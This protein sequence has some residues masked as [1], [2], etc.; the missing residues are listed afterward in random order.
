M[1]T[2]SIKKM[3][4]TGFRDHVKDEDV[5][6]AILELIDYNIDEAYRIFKN[7]TDKESKDITSYVNLRNQPHN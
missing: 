4:V 6:S 1:G 5:A 7:P 3:T 2:Q